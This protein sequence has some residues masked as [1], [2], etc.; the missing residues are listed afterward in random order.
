MGTGRRHFFAQVMQ[1]LCGF[2][3][4]VVPGKYAKK[5]MIILL[6]LFLSVVAAC[7]TTEPRRAADAQ[8]LV[9]YL[10]TY[11]MDTIRLE[12]FSAIDDLMY[13]NVTPKKSGDLDTSNFR[14]D[15]LR[16]IREKTE[17]TTMRILLTVGGWGDSEGFGQ[18][19]TDSG[20]RS[21]FI[22]QLLSFCRTYNFDGVD[23]DWEFP[24][25]FEEETAYSTLLV[26]TKHAFRPHRMVV[27][28][29]VAHG[30][31]LSAEAYQAVDHVH[32]MSYDHGTYLP[33][34]ER[35]IMDIQ[36]QLSFGVPREKLY[37]GIPFFGR[38][39][40]QKNEARSY[41][42]LT[43]QHHPAPDIDEVGNYHFNGV[44]TIRK[45][46]DYVR[47]QGLAGIMVWELGQDIAH[48]GTLLNTIRNAI[49]SQG[50]YTR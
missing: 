50:R 37:L 11:R 34:F 21:R 1:H 43:A 19:A 48:G 36:Q 23:F 41:A 13:Y 27:T 9:A 20:R 35:S 42:E 40:L 30:Q 44:A 5:L 26:E 6:S 29:A 8:R 45:K 31:R 15:A 4:V 7:V 46:V 32:L 17:G 16:F 2:G 18:M 24:A 12:W 25:T 49:S 3:D 28:V 33:T 22:R 10:P 47:Q 38:H 39:A 14:Y